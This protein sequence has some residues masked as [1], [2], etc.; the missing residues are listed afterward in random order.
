MSTH[1]VCTPIPA[2]GQVGH[3]W[4]RAQTLALAGVEGREI[5]SWR[6][7]RVDW[8]V[9]KDQVS[10]GR[11]HARVAAFIRGNAVTTVVARHMGDDME[12]MLTKL[13]VT[14]RLGIAGDAR[15]AV[16]SVC[17]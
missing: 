9:S 4:G 1:I 15:S 6:T 12:R 13:G 11:H 16:I 17:E 3:S 14:V 7:E 2:D 8:D 10:E 5:T